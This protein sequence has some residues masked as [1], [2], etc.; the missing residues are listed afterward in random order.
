MAKASKIST[1]SLRRR[2]REAGLITNK[3]PRKKVRVRACTSDVLPAFG[4]QRPDL[5]QPS[6]IDRQSI[7][8]QSDIASSIQ[9]GIGMQSGIRQQSDI[10]RM[11]TD[12]RPISDIGRLV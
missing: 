6:D 4:D 12:I 1:A 2:L 8:L 11:A 3:I 10:G 5:N 7:G 9:S